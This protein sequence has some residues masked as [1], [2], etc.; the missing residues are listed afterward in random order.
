MSAVKHPWFEGSI[1]FYK[2][3]CMM[4]YVR[5]SPSLDG[6][7]GGEACYPKCLRQDK[8]PLRDYAM[9]VAD[10]LNQKGNDFYVVEEKT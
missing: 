9:A 10:R 4:K 6:S 3:F 1:L 8:I 7:S 5:I 2:N